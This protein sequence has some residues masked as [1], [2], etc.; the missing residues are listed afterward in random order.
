MSEDQSQWE[1]EELPLE[2]D[3]RT[4]GNSLAARMQ[5]RQKQLEG[6]TTERFPIPG[7]EGVLE[8]ELKALGYATINAVITKN[9]KVRDPNVRPVYTMADQ[10]LMATVAFYEV[11]GQERNEIDGATWASVA[12]L[13]D[14]CP[15]GMTD[16]Q[17]LLFFVTDK[18]I[19]FLV[20]DW[21]DWCR[22]VRTDFD[23]EVVRDF[24][25]TG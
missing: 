9:E 18:R 20:A 21:S 23:K 6:Q 22:S 3:V 11:D 17:A 4:S 7:Y 15:E 8:V 16:R 24:V 10:I 2:E 25:T 12:A 5:A 14:D 19:A 1:P 13:L